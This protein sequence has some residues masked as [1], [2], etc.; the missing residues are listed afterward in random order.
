MDIDGKLFSQKD[1][2]R[3]IQV[4]SS[5]NTIRDI[6][7][8]L[9][10]ILE[11]AGEL[12]DAEAGSII[13]KQRDTGFFTIQAATG[14]KAEQFKGIKIPVGKGLVGWTIENNK[15]LLIPDVTKDER[16]Y[17]KSDKD[18]GFV[19]SS[20]LCVPLTIDDNVIGAIQVL[21][22]KGGGQYDEHDEQ[23]LTMLGAQAAATIYN[24][25]LYKEAQDAKKH[26]ESIVNGMADG[27]LLLDDEYKLKVANPSAKNDFNISDDLS[28]A[29]SALDL[30]VSETQS[31][32]QDTLDIALLKPEGSVLSCKTTYLDNDE[33]ELDGVILSFRNVTQIKEK[34]RRKSEILM[35]ISY[36]LKEPI[37]KLVA[38]QKENVKLT[39]DPEEKEKEKDVLE[40][41]EFIGDLINKLIYYSHMDAGPMR[42][43][44]KPQKLV[45]VIDEV[46]E[47]INE[48]MAHKKINVSHSVDYDERIKFDKETIY[49][50]VRN[51]LIDAI[52]RAPDGSN[53]T[54][55]QDNNDDSFSLIIT[56]DGKGY[57][58]KDM[59]TIFSLEGQIDRFMASD[60]SLSDINLSH[61][62]ANYIMEA[63][64]GTIELFTDNGKHKV[65][66]Q[67][68]KE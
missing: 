54:I 67:L 49:E 55:S 17:S 19:T 14:D 48:A 7:S 36:Q 25:M 57:S 40:R 16:W 28:S 32:R 24:L 26:I 58:A 18:S 34:E 33:G 60:E 20:I 50:S 35:L 51:I 21:N 8:L 23:V 37:E 41:I 61:A 45:P 29:S 68:P 10:K 42:L 3:I 13:L 63:H 9:N 62:F 27:V 12:I 1:L 65:K 31:S 43:E 44:R 4:F 30:I 38:T 47:E 53:V 6:D 22:K 66:L 39:T 11:Y 15:P 56:D 64:G 46:V 5:M 2:I 52:D 59:E